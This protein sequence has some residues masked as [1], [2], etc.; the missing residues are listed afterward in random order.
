M[1]LC[2]FCEEA[3][4][5]NYLKILNLESC[6][7]IKAI[8]RDCYENNLVYE[9][10]L[11]GK[12]MCPKCVENCTNCQKSICKENAISINN[13]YYCQECESETIKI[14]VHKIIK[15][16]GSEPENIADFAIKVRDYTILRY[17]IRKKSQND[18]KNLFEHLINSCEA[19]NLNDLWKNIFHCLRPHRNELDLSKLIEIIPELDIKDNIYVEKVINLWELS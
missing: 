3:I 7:H 13:E 19:Q 14:P 11:C 12:I 18:L 2:D 1:L 6:E 16:L 5:K 17:F 9:C 8:C 10:D 15:F 4:E